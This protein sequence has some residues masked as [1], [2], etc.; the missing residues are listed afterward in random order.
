[1]QRPRVGLVLAGGGI[2][3]YGFHV[4]ALA[5]LADHV[6]WEVGSAEIVLGTSSGSIVS[7]FVR[8]G[9][10]P[11]EL[12]SRVLATG[13]DAE[14]DGPLEALVGRANFVGPALRKGPLALG[15]V[16][17]EFKRGRSLRPGH[18][19]AGLLPQGR[20][21]TAA[22]R[23]IVEPFHPH[24][25]PEQPLWIVATETTTGR[26]HVF[27]RNGN[28]Q[29]VAVAEAVRAS[30]AIPGYFAPVTINGERFVD[31]GLHAA[32]NADLLL[33][34]ALDTIVISS[35]LS[36]DANRLTRAPLATALRAYPRR[37]LRSNVARLRDA[38][39]NVL[40][41]EPD[42]KLSRAMG[43]NAMA[44]HRLRPIVEATTAFVDRRLTTLSADDELAL[45]GLTAERR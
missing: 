26:R 21:P 23:E 29:D 15:L 8:G 25:W 18:I 27:G 4:G 6:G 37:R 28:G 14:T 7:A 41:L 9:L 42:Q 34:E 10:S 17:E 3:G 5:A 38:G 31:G 40:V 44:P 24:G 11:I 19:L 43:L 39:V 22:I 33:D 16:V 45:S 36:V 13:P 32:D 12:R 20:M 35:P 30:C 2:A 1:M